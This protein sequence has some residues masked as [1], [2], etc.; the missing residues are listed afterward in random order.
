MCCT[1][2][3]Q[4]TWSGQEKALLIEYISVSGKSPVVDP[5]I[6][7][8]SNEYKIEHLNGVMTEIPSDVCDW[9]T[10]SR[11]KVFSRHINETM[12]YWL[13]IV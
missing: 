12:K 11:L 7:N 6:Y 5:E 3:S 9:D 8:D 13:H 10:D 2:K 4:T 1:C